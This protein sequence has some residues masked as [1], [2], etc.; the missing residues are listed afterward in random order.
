MDIITVALSAAKGGSAHHDLLLTNEVET[1]G[2]AGAENLDV[3]TFA[4]NP[5]FPADRKW[6]IRFR[7]DGTITIVL[8]L[9]D[10]GRGWFSGYFAGLVVARLGV[11]FRRVRIYYSVTLPAVLQ[12][13]KPPST[14]F[15]RGHI[16][17]VASA[18]AGI[19]ERMCDQVIERGRLAFAAIA[20]VGTADIGFDQSIGRFFVLD[21]ARSKDQFRHPFASTSATRSYRPARFSVPAGQSRP[22]ASGP[23]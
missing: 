10:Y 21:R 22:A 23:T 6:A 19:I 12:T 15:H 7:S 14:V 2:G 5:I 16:G 13:P 9:K 17:P 4:S 3:E 18:V 8:G 1:L 20:G 11:P